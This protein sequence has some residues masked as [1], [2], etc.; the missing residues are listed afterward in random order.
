MRRSKPM[1]NFGEDSRD[2][3]RNEIFLSNEEK[4]L[5]ERNLSHMKSEQKGKRD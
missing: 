3:Y 4:Y 5:E 2:H 1:M